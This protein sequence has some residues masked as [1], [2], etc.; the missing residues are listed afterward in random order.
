MESFPRQSS[1]LAA[2]HSCKGHIPLL[3]SEQM[4]RKVSEHQNFKTVLFSLVYYHQKLHGQGSLPQG[5]SRTAGGWIIENRSSLG[6]TKIV[7]VAL[8]ETRYS[9]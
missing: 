9:S 7:F 6:Q 1:D 3:R 8:H 2:L 5:T 4:G